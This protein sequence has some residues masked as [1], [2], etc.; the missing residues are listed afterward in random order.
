MEIFLTP[1]ALYILAL[2]GMLTHFL[3]KNIKGE[4]VTEIR[5]YFKDHFKSTFLALVATTVGFL[6]YYF[7][8]ASGQNADIFGS[9]GIGYMF[10]SFFNRYE[11]KEKQ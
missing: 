11:T 1:W 2:L 9:F 6:I 5:D 8:L 3:K 4:T 7:L 10:D